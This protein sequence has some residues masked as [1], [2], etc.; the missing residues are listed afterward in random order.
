[1]MIVGDGPERDGIEDCIRKYGLEDVVILTGS[2]TDVESYLSMAD[3]FVMP[4]LFE[5]LPISAIEAQTSGLP[6]VI[7]QNVDPMVC[8][9]EK[10][11]SLPIDVDGVSE[12]V[13]TIRK[14]SDGRLGNKLM[15]NSELFNLKRSA[16]QLEHVY[17]S[18]IA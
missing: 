6:I 18:G 17:Q 1:L 3:I 7:S 4:S 12:W 10:F 13:H 16:Q 5:G 8:I 9:S 2:V 14:I 15:K 11:Y